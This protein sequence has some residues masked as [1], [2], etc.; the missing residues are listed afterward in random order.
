MLQPN[1]S[2]PDVPRAPSPWHLTGSAWLVAVR[3][4]ADSPALAA[5]M[6]AD[7]AARRRGA[8]SLLMF[9]DYTQSPCGPY[10]EL[11]FIPGNYPFADGRR[12]YSISRI[13]V[14]TWD[15]VVNGRINWGIPKDRADFDVS[16]EDDG[17]E[18]IRV[19]SD[20]REL[21]ELRLRAW[22]VTLP[23]HGGLLPKALR[24]LGQRFEGKTFLY[25]PTMRGWASP[26]KLVDWRFN[27]DLFPDVAGGRVLGAFR[28]KSFNLAFPRANVLPTT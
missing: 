11:M 4:P 27:A 5:F 16:R 7:V 14:S 18:H 17:T 19:H 6:P 23:V 13:L 2:L 28:I 9:V 12:H 24:L 10:R 25:A 1:G 20:G 26:G 15:S 3:L 21:A 22:P 8:L